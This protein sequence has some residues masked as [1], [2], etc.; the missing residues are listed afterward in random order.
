MGEKSGIKKGNKGGSFFSPS[1]LSHTL[2]YYP[3][4]N[5]PQITKES[6]VDY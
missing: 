5:L 4:Y 6:K 2:S 3:L 1:S